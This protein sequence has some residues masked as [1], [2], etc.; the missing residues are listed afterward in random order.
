MLYLDRLHDAVVQIIQV[1]KELNESFFDRE[2][3]GMN[4]RSR[5]VFTAEFDF[6]DGPWARD[7]YRL[8]I[9]YRK[10]FNATEVQLLH[11][12]DQFCL[13]IRELV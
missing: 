13:G 2:V 11:E 7:E 3:T 6:S 5:A 10:S 12:S 8:S 4:L 1:A 9:S